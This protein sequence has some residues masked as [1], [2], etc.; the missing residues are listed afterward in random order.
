[1]HFLIFKSFTPNSNYGQSK[2][3]LKIAKNSLP[4]MGYNL[5]YVKIDPPQ[6]QDSSISLERPY[7]ELLN[8]LFNFQIHHF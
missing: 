5:W 6:N 4:S 7:K 1:M 8:A 2:K 3:G